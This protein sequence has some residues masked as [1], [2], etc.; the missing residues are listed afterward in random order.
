MNTA[1]ASGLF[2]AAAVMAALSPGLALAAGDLATKATKL[3][4][5]AMGGGEAGY[6]MSQKSYD[7]ET[8]KAYRLKIKASGQHACS[9]RGP[10]FYAAVYMRQLQAGEAEFLNPTF[11]SI[12]FDDASEAEINF[13]PVRTGT[14]TLGCKGL[15][16]KGMTVTINVK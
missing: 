13:V 9:F 15:E 1:K 16:Q 14:F 11:T 7:L 8:G 3:P 2:L 10:E 4:D 6:D 5:L 12:E